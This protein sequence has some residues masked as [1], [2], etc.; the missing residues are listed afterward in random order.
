MAGLMPAHPVGEYTAKFPRA[1][2]SDL[3]PRV[4]RL[5]RTASMMRLRCAK[6]SSGNL[7][8]VGHQRLWH[9]RRMRRHS[10]G[11]RAARSMTLQYSE[12]MLLART[13]AP[14]SASVLGCALPSTRNNLVLWRRDD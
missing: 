9:P 1:A 2:S 7:G 11:P 10:A 13:K 6:R 5:T 4:I 14:S 3:G 8:D 12:W